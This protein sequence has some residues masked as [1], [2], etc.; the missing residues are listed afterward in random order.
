MN[1][2]DITTILGRGSKFEGKLTFEGTVRV[3]GQFSGEIETEGGLIIGETA[4]VQAQIKA[5]RVVVEGQVRG[6]LCAEVDLEVRATARIQGNVMS[7]SLSVDRGAIIEGQI[8]M[9]GESVARAP[10]RP[11]ERPT[12][13][14]AN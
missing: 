3:D 13:S 4:Q 11:P 1:N 6:D 9:A 7:P 14:P 8:K 12:A 10:N 2:D 5:G